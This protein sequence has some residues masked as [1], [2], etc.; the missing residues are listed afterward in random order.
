[1]HVFTGINIYNVRLIVTTK[2]GCIDTA[3]HLYDV[4]DDF[5]F[6][7]P[8]AFTPNDDGIN[9][10]FIPKGI[11]FDKNSYHMYIYDR[12]GNFIFYSDDPAKGWDGRANHGVD[13]AQEDVFVWKIDLKDNSGR[14][15]KYMGH[16]TIVK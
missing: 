2:Y 11:G 3:Y 6:Y 9:E 1:M 14:L 16:V 15:H 8:N 13:I 5:V 7:I 10:I 4:A 12:W